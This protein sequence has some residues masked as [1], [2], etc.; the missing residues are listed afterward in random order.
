MTVWAILTTT[1]KL[2]YNV[3]YSNYE[4]KVLKNVRYFFQKIAERSSKANKIDIYLYMCEARSGMQKVGS[5]GLI[6]A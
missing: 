3:Y 1:R 6:T 4:C 5:I 2:G